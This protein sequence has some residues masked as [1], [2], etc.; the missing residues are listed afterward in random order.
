MPGLM[1]DSDFGLPNYAEKPR[2]IIRGRRRNDVYGLGPSFKVTDRAKK[3][4]ESHDPHG[5]DFVECDAF[6][7]KGDRLPPYWFVDAKRMVVDFDRSKSDFETYPQRFPGDLENASNP[8]ILKI[9]RFV[10]APGLSND[11]H[12]FYVANYD[13]HFI[14]DGILA[15]GWR[16]QKLVGAVFTPLQEPEADEKPDWKWLNHPC[17]NSESS[18]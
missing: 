8:A 9:S 16:S 12:S 5:F 18:P 3:L 17:W 4:L 11:A 10:P 13:S 7:P 2:L 14:V 1:Y 15:D 6:T